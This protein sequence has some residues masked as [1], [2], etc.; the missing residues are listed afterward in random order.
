MSSTPSPARATQIK[1]GSKEKILGTLAGWMIRILGLTLRVKFQHTQSFEKIDGPIILIFW[2]GQIIPAIVAWTRKCP[3]PH[4]LS[5]L[6][7]AS[8]DGAIIEHT[9]RTFGLGAVRGSS[10]R[11]ATAALLE[12]KKTLDAGNDISITP[13]GPRGP[14]RTL[15]AGPLKL[16]QLTGS[17]LV[18]LRVT[19]SAS[20]KLK[21]WD[22]FE[23]PKPFSC[24]HLSIDE[25]LHIPRKISDEDFEQMRLTIEN[26]LSQ[27]APIH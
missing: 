23:I 26:D 6:T 11:R 21:T 16:S 3:R 9:L 12:L 8:K 1:G 5:A 25:P 27:P 24:I 17:A 2:H 7:S 13:D 10:S 14:A 4:G 20:W 15:Q 22:R 18:S 19:C